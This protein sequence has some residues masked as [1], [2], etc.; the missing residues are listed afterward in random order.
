MTYT[1]RALI[2]ID[3]QQEYFDGPLAVHHPPREESLANIAT[4]I[5]DAEAAGLPIVVVQHEAP[6][7]APV[8]AEGSE[9]WRLHPVIAERE[10][11]AWKR[12]T[13]SVASVFAD[14]SVVT[15]L[16]DLEVETVTLV[17]YMTNNCV[18]GSA[19][20]AEPLGLDV[21]VLS[22][23]T[24]A[25]HLANE[26]GTVSARQLHETLMVLLHSN[27]AA[28]T[29]TAAWSRAASTSTPIAKSD[30]LTSATQGAAAA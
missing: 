15:W 2:V 6:A 7:G 9:G 19:A 28:V 11:P 12:S 3:V 17:G 23:A 10:T 24:G 16:R 8:F 25:I 21:E 20:A 13:K 30:L 22:D 1:R 29:T 18:I 26:A 5:D 4:A 27:F 14:A